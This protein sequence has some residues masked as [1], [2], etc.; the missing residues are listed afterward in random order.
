MPI[1]VTIIHKIVFAVFEFLLEYYCQLKKNV[2]SRP[3]DI[4]ALGLTATT[5]SIWTCSVA[6]LSKMTLH[7]DV[8][9]NDTHYD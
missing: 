9:Y 1:F 2:S 7:N 8:Q 5:F 4:D 3:Q 6:K